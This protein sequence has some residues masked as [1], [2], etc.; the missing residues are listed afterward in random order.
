MADNAKVTMEPG[1]PLVV[2]ANSAYAFTERD[3]ANKYSVDGKIIRPLEVYTNRLRVVE[4]LYVDNEN[5]ILGEGTVS[6]ANMV[7][8]DVVVANSA[9][10]ANGVVIGGHL[11]ADSIST[12]H[13]QANSVG[14]AELQADCVIASK[15]QI[16]ELSDISDDMGILL[17]GVIK[18]GDSGQRLEFAADTG[19]GEPGLVAFD[20]DDVSRTLFNDS[21]VSIISGAATDGDVASECKISLGTSGATTEG[22]I[23]M[24]RGTYTL[25]RT[26]DGGI[27]T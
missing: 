7:Q 2:A 15:V 23:F 19:S 10:I 27:A 3:E 24:L 12:T 16:S 21:G 8:T 13:L 20:E 25:T 6:A 11:Q 1:A 26:T 9:Q 22:S 14:T 5:I 4:A 18:T 17:T